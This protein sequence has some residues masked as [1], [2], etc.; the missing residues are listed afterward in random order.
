MLVLTQ[1]GQVLIIN[2]NITIKVLEV[3]GDQVKIGINAPRQVS[4]HR[5]EHTPPSRRQTGTRR[6]RRQASDLPLPEKQCLDLKPGHKIIMIRKRQADC[7]ISLPFFPF[8]ALAA[9]RPLYSYRFFCINPVNC[10][11]PAA[12]EINL[13]ISFFL[14]RCQQEPARTVRPLP[15]SP[16][17]TWVWK[18][19]P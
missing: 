18:G 13:K 8:P 17:D 1:K 10:L 12:C 19:R 5:K 9:R 16:Q 2:D 4:V 14:S 7:K 11:M 15:A 3:K 6:K